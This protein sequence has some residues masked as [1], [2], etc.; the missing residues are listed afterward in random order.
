MADSNRDCQD[1]TQDET[2]ATATDIADRAVATSG[3]QIDAPEPSK[4]ALKKAAKQ[5]KL[6][7]EKANKSSSKKVSEVGKTEARKAVAK[8][9]L[10]KIPG[11]ALI[12]I[13]VAK[14]DDFA[15]WYQQVLTKGDMLDY[16]DVSGCYIL[17][18]RRWFAKRGQKGD[19]HSIN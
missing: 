6:A 7:A 9:P 5:E 15:G 4:N 14:E 1:P 13:D 8:P 17:K 19:A 3:D 11:A 18:V 12:G 10:K 16:Y 2:K